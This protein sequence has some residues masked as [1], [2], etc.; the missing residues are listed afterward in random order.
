MGLIYSKMKI[1]HFPE[2][3]A[4]LSPDTQDIR[5]PLHI[6]IKP[7]NV[8]AH[9]CW[10]C[11]YRYENVQLGKDMHIKD[12]IP[13]QKMMEI[14]DDIIE[15]DIKAVTFSGGGD[16][17]Y[18][19]FLLEVA[20]KLAASPVK[21]ASLTNG[22]RLKGEL[23]EIFAHCAS[24]VRISIDGWDDKSYAKYRSIREGEFSKVINNIALFAKLGGQCRLGISLIVD[25]E[26]HSH[27]YEFAAKLRDIG[28]SSIKVSACIIDDN[29]NKNAAYHQPIFHKVKEQIAEATSNLKSNTFE[30]L[31]AYHTLD[32]RFEKEYDWCPYIQIMPVIGADLNIYSCQDKAYETHGLLGSIRNM[33]FKDFWFSDK[34]RFFKVKPYNDCRHHCI[35]NERNK[36]ILEYLDTDQ[37]HLEFV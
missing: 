3:L 17:F 31:D 32:S 28:V 13:K 33:H 30:V 24:W 7:T 15:M 35:A 8:C 22:A 2:K 25:H 12:T 20:K 5:P 16:P 37:E 18:Y 26:N 29:A 14:I 27:I 19:P 10:Y 23:A 4:S 9:S 1:F 34:N 36:L 11:A 21:F 6:R